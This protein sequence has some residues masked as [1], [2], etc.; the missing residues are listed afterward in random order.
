[1]IT[2]AIDSYLALR[3]AQG[4]VFRAQEKLIRSFAGFASERGEDHIHTATAIEWAS[5]SLSLQRR[6][7][8]LKVV[9]AFARHLQLED[10]RHEVP[11]RLVLYGSEPSAE[12]TVAQSLGIE[13]RVEWRGNVSLARAA[14]ALRSAHRLV[15]VISADHPFSIPAKLFDYRAA[16]RPILLIADPG[17]AAA[18]VL[19]GAQA[20]RTIAATRRDQLEDLICEDS[21]ALAHGG[22]PDVPLGSSFSAA[23]QM[24]ALAG[25]L[26]ELLASPQ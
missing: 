3:R 22:L 23:G 10:P 18:A 2:E 24:D 17:H 7:H 26:R 21:V 20:H 12:L 15:A 11:L 25:W 14:E 5:Q 19:A 13:D 1:M 6:D 16:A 9:A 8:R 4:F